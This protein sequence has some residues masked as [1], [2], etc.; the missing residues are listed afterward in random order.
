MSGVVA[1]NK[2]DEEVREKNDSIAR[3]DAEV[4]AVGKMEWDILSLER[5]ALKER[6]GLR[7]MVIYDDMLD[8]IHDLR[9]DLAS[10]Y[11]LNMDL[12]IARERINDVI[13]DLII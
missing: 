3:R 7:R 8:I 13:E 10:L 9:E 5:M 6:T 12:L 2:A 11:N 1:D 4:K